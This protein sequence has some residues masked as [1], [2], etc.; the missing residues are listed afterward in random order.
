MTPQALKPAAHARWR[1]DAWMLLFDAVLGGAVLRGGGPALMFALSALRVA[2]E[3]AAHQGAVQPAHP[4]GSR[5]EAAPVRPVDLPQP[6]RGWLQSAPAAREPSADA[7]AMRPEDGAANLRIL[8]PAAPRTGPASRQVIALPAEGEAIY[9]PGAGAVLLHPFLQ[10]LFGRSGLLEGAD[11]RDA[12][13]RDRGVHLLGLLAF[14]GTDVPEHQLLLPKLL[15]GCP[16]DEPL[17]PVDLDEEDQAR[18]DA[19]LRAVLGHWTALRSSSP[20]WLRAQF[21]LREGKLEDVDGGVRLT[22]ERRAQDVL[23]A[24]LPWGIGAFGLPWLRQ[25]IFVHWLD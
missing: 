2:R 8:T 3:S 17:E 23:L 22:L 19:L 15:C 14:G 24:R 5:P 6:W 10:E 1:R 7:P 13:A 25:R 18:C 4:P 9:L 12:P 16:F 21:F 20:A 11:F